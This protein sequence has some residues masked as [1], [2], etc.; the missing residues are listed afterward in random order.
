MI[1]RFYR[2]AG[3]LVKLRDFGGFRMVLMAEGRERMNGGVGI[4][5][6]NEHERLD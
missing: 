6:G 2:L 3:S 1:F 5:T 4:K